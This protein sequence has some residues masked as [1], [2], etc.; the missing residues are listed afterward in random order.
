MEQEQP[1]PEH[2]EEHQGGEQPNDD[3]QLDDNPQLDENPQPEGHDLD[4]DEIL[5]LLENEN[6]DQEANAEEAWNHFLGLLA[7]EE[8][9]V[10]SISSENDIMIIIQEMWPDASKAEIKAI[11]DR[12]LDIYKKS[13][14]PAN[15]NNKGNTKYYDVEAYDNV[16]SNIKYP[17]GN[18]EAQEEA[19]RELHR[20]AG[21]NFV[22]RNFSV[23]SRVLHPISQLKHTDDDGDDDDGNEGEGECRP[24]DF[25]KIRSRLDHKPPHWHTSVLR[26]LAAMKVENWARVR[27]HIIMALRTNPNCV[28]ALIIQDISREIS[29]KSFASDKPNRYKILAILNTEKRRNWERYFTRLSEKYSQEY[30]YV[31]SLW[32][33]YAYLYQGDFYNA[34]RLFAEAAE[35]K[36]YHAMH[37]MSV[38][39]TEGLG[40]ATNKSAACVY[41]K[42]ALD[43]SLG[44]NI[45]GFFISS[46]YTFVDDVV[47]S[48]TYFMSAAK[49]GLNVAKSNVGFSYKQGD[50]TAVDAYRAFDCFKDAAIHGYRRAHC[51]LGIMYQHGFGVEVDL[52]KAVDSY[53]ASEVLDS[54]T[55]ISICM[56]DPKTFAAFRKRAEDGDTTAQILC[57]AFRNCCN[58]YNGNDDEY[59]ALL[60]RAAVEG[61]STDAMCM[62]AI[63]YGD[64][65]IKDKTD[66]WLTKARARGSLVA[67]ILSGIYYGSGVGLR[68]SALLSMASFKRANDFVGITEILAFAF[69]GVHLKLGGYCDKNPHEDDAL[70]TLGWTLELITRHNRGYDYDTV[71]QV[72]TQGTENGNTEAKL[73]LKRF[74]HYVNPYVCSSLNK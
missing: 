19:K 11:I 54:K 3:P 29:P 59:I 21:L 10:K 26:A 48:N 13:M 51:Q 6:S 69:A 50:G 70:Y 74:N 27:E 37:R 8:I 46:K 57:Y 1:Q 25:D 24:V 23:K 9:N 40:V 73:G 64:K 35:K 71:I 14:G 44:K 2:V 20:T 31:L 39:Y 45:M 30:P 36:C 72:Y 66:K 18:I 32:G 63:Y 16:V 28:A 60:E 43:Y 17:V 15:V 65:D 42:E 34:A 55:N 67:T 49:D 33:E 58:T 61:K 52:V 56:K 68:K 5:D 62:L 12:W 7:R 53:I 4:L 38:M 47:L 22:K 41:G